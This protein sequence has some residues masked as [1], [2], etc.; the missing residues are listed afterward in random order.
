MPNFST[1]QNKNKLIIIAVIYLIFFIIGILSYQDFGISVDEW[2]LR[3]MGY[4]NLKY[5]I[6]IFSQN[7]TAKLDEILLIPKLSDYSGNT[8]GVI[9][10]LPMALIEYL[11]NITDSQKYYFI[12][13]Y[14]NHL[15]F[16]L[17]NFYFF[18]LVAERFDNWI[19]GVFGALFLF[20]SPRIFAESFYNHKDILF[21]SLFIINLYYG[22]HFLK[23]QSIKNSI[24]FSFTSAL[25]VYIRI[26][27]IIIAPVIVF[28]YLPKIFKK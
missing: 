4:V 19:Y 8:H 24:L 11:F 6:E 3:L 18:L 16:L 17:A 28:F 25:A 9:F 5:V 15:L 12:R 26:M 22:I 20:L 13:H 2:D 21:L 1:K 7:A 10:S 27:G 14:F 23:T